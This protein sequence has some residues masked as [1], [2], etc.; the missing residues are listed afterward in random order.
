MVNI[1]RRLRALPWPLQCVACGSAIREG[2]LCPPCL[3]ELP[4]VRAACPGCALPL[5]GGWR[6]GLCQRRP[7]PWEGCT[8]ALWYRQP[9]PLLLAAFKYRGRLTV[10]RSLAELLAQRLPDRPEVD[11]LLPVPM[12]WRRRWQRGFNQAAELAHWLGRDLDLP[13]LPAI[14]RHRATP[15][16][17]GLDAAARR[18]NLSDAFRL[19]RPVAGLR[20]AVV[21]DVM[22]T[23]QTGRALAAL[24]KRH[25]AQRVEL[26]CVARTLPPGGRR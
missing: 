26:W 7:P 21:D 13:V 24:L 25:G 9:V 18:H 8:G 12:H 23:G 6:C 17:Q 5:P 22:T 10:G 4:R 3:Q 19:R 20:L 1:S 11:V 2:G 15:P 16:Q 14:A